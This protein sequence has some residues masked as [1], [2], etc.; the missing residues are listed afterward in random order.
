MDCGPACLKM[1]ADFHHIPVSLQK[2]RELCSI[3]RAGVSLAGIA[4]AAEKIGLRS[5]GVKIAFDDLDDM[6][7]LVQFPLP[8]IAHW[9]HNHF[10]VIFKVKNGYVWISDPAHGKI[11]LSRKQF[12]DNWLS[13]RDRG[14]VLGLE[15]IPGFNV[16]ID[17]DHERYKGWSKILGYLGTHRRLL[18]QFIIGLLGGLVIQAIIPFLS[19]SLIDVGILRQNIHFVW[20]VLIAQL[21]LFISQTSVQF[22]QSWILLHIGRRINVAMISDFLMQLV[23]LPLGYFDSKNIGDLMQRIQDNSRVE[24]FLTGNVLTIVFSVASFLVFSVILLFFKPLI[25]LVF[26]LFSTLYF[27]WVILFMKRRRD[28]DYLA[29]QQASDQQHTLYELITGMQEIKLQG[30]ERKRRW[31]WIDIQAIFFRIQGKSLALKQYQDIGAIFFNRIKDIIITI[32]AALAVIKGEITLGTLVSIQYIVGQLNA[33]FEQFIGF[34]RSAQDARISLDRMGEILDVAPEDPGDIQTI[35][36]LPAEKSILLDNVSFRYSNISDPVLQH[37]SIAIPAGKVTAIVGVSGSGKTTLLKLLLGF[38]PVSSGQITIGHIP[39]PTINKKYWRSRCG[40][41]MQEGFIFSDT[42]ANNI[43]ESDES[44]KFEKLDKALRVANISEFVYGLPNSYNTMIGAKG[45]GVSQ[46]Q[47]Q[48]LLIA[49]AVYKDPEFLFFDEATNSLDAT[50]EKTIMHNLQT[51]Y[52][53]KTVVI[54][55][56]RLSTVKNAD[57]IIVLDKGSV[58]E[59]GTHTELVTAKGKYYELVQNQL[60][61]E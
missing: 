7:G 20:I 28:L 2:L 45:T 21:V 58:I 17:D 56:H 18:T 12:L 44:V 34:I 1:V 42:I 54:V 60:D 49:R 30:S 61:L 23:R 50:N 39:L 3:T 16:R 6:P 35:H 11:K 51:F 10:V 31:K 57:N 48:R 59:Q 9:H 19:Q 4:D 13:D 52:A 36:E 37:L 5:L 14:V 38:Y 41:V 40:T 24:S 53:Q 29:F 33:P 15:P 27:L 46:G 43:G 26:I 8:A 22:I 47:K 25:F 32:I 55:A